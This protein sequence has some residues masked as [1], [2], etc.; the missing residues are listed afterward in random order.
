MTT[1]EFNR[2]IGLFVLSY[3]RSEESSVGEFV[4]A[5]RLQQLKELFDISNDQIESRMDAEPDSWITV[6]GNHIPLDKDKNPIGG[7]QKA[8][9]IGSPEK[10][11]GKR[12]APGVASKKTSLTEDQRKDYSDKISAIKKEQKEIKDW[13][14]NVNDKNVKKKDYD[15]EPFR[16][17]ERRSK[18]LAEQAEK[19]AGEMPAGTLFTRGT[20]LYEKNDDGTWTLTNKNGSRQ[21][22]NKT[23]ASEMSGYTEDADYP[24][25]KFVE[26]SNQAE[27]V[28]D[29]QLKDPDTYKG[30][31]NDLNSLERKDL[32]KKA[33][34]D[35]EFKEIVD[36]VVLY[37]EGGYVD[38][39][40]AA[41]ELASGGLN[42]AS[43]QTVGEYANGNLYN[44]RD[45]YKGQNLKESDSSIAGGM[46]HL[47]EMINNSDPVDKPLYRVAQDR[48]IF[49]SGDHEPYVPPK[50]GDTISITAPTSFTDSH[51]VEQEL[52]GSKMGDVIHYELESGA[53]AVNVAGL[54]RYKQS[55]YLSS[56]NF[57]VFD[58]QTKVTKVPIFGHEEPTAAA[59]KRGIKEDEWGYK[60]YER[61]TCNVKIRRVGNVSLSGKHDAADDAL[62]YEEHFDDRMVLKDDRRI[63]AEPSSWITLENGAHIPLDE[64]GKALGGAGGWA[65]GK[66]FSEA[67]S[68]N[69]NRE[70]K[71]RSEVKTKLNNFNEQY[72]RNLSEIK[73]VNGAEKYKTLDGSTWEKSRIFEGK[74]YWT[75]YE[76]GEMLTEKGILDLQG[77]LAFEISDKPK[78]DGPLEF[79][80]GKIDRNVAQSTYEQILKNQYIEDGEATITPQECGEL[81]SSLK[82]YGSGGE[83]YKILA[84]QA[85]D[86]YK[87]EFA[88]TEGKEHEEY[89][90]E[91]EKLETL[92]K[93]TDKYKGKIY[94]GMSF[95]SEIPGHENIEKDYL[96]TL[97]VGKEISMGHIASWSKNEGTA[98]AYSMMAA[99][100]SETGTNYS[101]VFEC[102]NKKY[103]GAAGN[104]EQELLSTNEAKYRIVSNRRTYNDDYNMWEYRVKLEEI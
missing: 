90:K 44:F 91:A 33:K 63:D 70:E 84:A 43:A 76:T 68:K 48:N 83:C 55:E 92:I 80:Y 72:K 99:D 74:Q 98:S 8:L 29:I 5:Y 49:K 50:V 58:V 65:K 88:Q 12:P 9:G 40:K 26:N 64:N 38:Q 100:F 6:N 34:K 82:R 21:V 30:W 61:Y 17:S 42:N 94:R 66:E 11:T 31:A 28:Q 16:E 101:L 75:N 39:R 56:G 62:R 47:T 60:Y 14:K 20:N 102:E 3:Y 51:E 59:K 87:S 86:K 19:L 22:T 36:S 7:Q 54:S 15:P 37:T 73:P 67:N 52:S 71:Q 77:E 10:K 69:E 53:N 13:Q 45:L 85:P 79:E 78:Y 81:L 32:V 18:E 2:K 41:E 103:A 1:K 95:N 25:V 46:A 97:E 104:P 35:P 23:A 93:Y 4:H 96:S 27:M 57:E 89:V 24:P